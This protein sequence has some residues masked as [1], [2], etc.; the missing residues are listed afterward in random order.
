MRPDMEAMAP[1]PRGPNSRSENRRRLR[2]RSDL[3]RYLSFCEAWR[4]GLNDSVLAQLRMAGLTDPS[5][6]TIAELMR[7]LNEIDAASASTLPTERRVLWRR[8]ADSG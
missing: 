5:S 6:R 2:R 1:P 3:A 7:E 4:L 8:I